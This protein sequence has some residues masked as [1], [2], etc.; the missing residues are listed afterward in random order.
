[1]KMTKIITTLS[2]A[3]CLSFANN[4]DEI[5]EKAIELLKDDK[6]KAAYTLLEDTYTQNIYDNK[7][8]FLLGTIA[9]KLDNKEEAIGYFEK[10]LQRDIN[11][12]RVRLELA[13][14][15]YKKEEYEKAKELLLVVKDSNPPKQVAQNVDIFLANIDA[16]LKT[17]TYNLTLGFLYDTNVNSGPFKNNLTIYDT[18]FN[19]D[20]EAKQQR[21][22]AFTFGAGVNGKVKKFDLN[23]INALSFDMVKYLD[24]TDYDS[25]QFN[26]SSGLAFK[27]DKLHL[28][29][30]VNYNI[31]K[32]GYGNPYYSMYYG[33][34]PQVSFVL[35]KKLMANVGVGINKKHFYQNLQ[36]RSMV[37]NVAPSLTYL[38]DN[39]SSFTLGSN[40]QE[41]DSRNET[42]DNFSY[43]INGNYFKQFN[44]S[45]G[46][47]TQVSYTR[48]NF[49]GVQLAFDGDLR[50]DSNYGFGANYAYSLAKYNTN[51]SL[52]Y[53]Y[54]KNSSPIDLYEYTKQLIS[55]NI[56]RRY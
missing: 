9:K 49:R 13:S 47:L 52:G 17:Y 53:N 6:N 5:N 28:K 31:T 4:I 54:M 24:V 43:G 37:Y 1:M 42:K 38:I 51:I 29:T 34:T 40:I 46:I 14:L 55:L 41:E 45:H 22:F 20:D 3:T 50:K 33:I 27:W 11:A 26:I 10:L 18:T 25:Y 7:T 35:S 8:L 30:P 36:D 48:T 12:Q 39:T 2:L 16:K 23:F 19:L 44:K 15:Y 56:N 32:I 21:D